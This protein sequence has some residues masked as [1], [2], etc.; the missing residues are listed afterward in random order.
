MT[1]SGEVYRPIRKRTPQ[2]SRRDEYSYPEKRHISR[3]KPNPILH[4]DIAGTI[5]KGLR[6]WRGSANLIHTNDRNAGC[7]GTQ[8]IRKQVTS[9]NAAR[10]S[11][12]HMI[13]IDNERGI[14]KNSTYD[15]EMKNLILYRNGPVFR[16][17]NVSEK[18]SRADNSSRYKSPAVVQSYK[19][20]AAEYQ[21]NRLNGHESNIRFS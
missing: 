11:I 5:H 13:G 3:S 1:I 7:L 12:V 16:K 14:Q 4:G 2:T 8:R 17:D 10:S 21:L 9:G 6:T 15:S 18:V 19:M 20:R